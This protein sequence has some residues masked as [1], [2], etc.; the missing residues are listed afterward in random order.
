MQHKA[1]LILDAVTAL[2]TGLESTSDRVEQSRAYK[3][4]DLPALAVNMGPLN[5]TVQTGNVSNAVLEI[6]IDIYVGGS[7]DQIDD[8]ILQSH[9]EIQA[10]LMANPNFGLSFVIDTEAKSLDAPEIELGAKVI[11]VT[12]ARFQVTFRHATDSWE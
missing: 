4:A 7:E 9:A 10:A 3:K 1:K 6:N 11:A 12:T 2:V 5:T 8:L